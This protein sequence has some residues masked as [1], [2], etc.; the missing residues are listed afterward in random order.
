VADI[1]MNELSAVMA[2]QA[3][4]PSR[5]MVFSP[6]SN[7][8]NWR[9]LMATY[10]KLNVVRLDAGQAY[11][12]REMKDRPLVT[13]PEAVQSLIWVTAPHEDYPAHIAGLSARR[14]TTG[15]VQSI[16][17]ADIGAGPLDATMQLDTTYRLR[18]GNPPDGPALGS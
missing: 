16:W 10:P 6:L 14:L 9:V 17:V 8:V 11:V 15:R 3:P 5:I 18:R 7:T 4:D 12:F 1:A 2:A 13:L